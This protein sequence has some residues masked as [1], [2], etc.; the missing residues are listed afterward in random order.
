MTFQ[1]LDAAR[2]AAGIDQKALCAAAGVHVTTYTAIKNG[3]SGGT[4]RTVERLQRALDEIISER[5]A[6]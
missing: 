1:E 2:E 3:R 4:V 5:A 6:A